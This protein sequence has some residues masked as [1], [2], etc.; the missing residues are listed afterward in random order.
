MDDEH[1][2]DDINDGIDELPLIQQLASIERE[3]QEDSLSTQHH[4]DWILKTVAVRIT[5]KYGLQ[6]WDNLG[7]KH[8]NYIVNDWKEADTGRRSIDEKLSALRWLT[9]KIGKANL[10]PRTNRELGVE[11]GARCTH[12]GNVISDERLA[13]IRGGIN[14]PRVQ[15]MIGLGREFGLRLKEASLFRPHQDATGN[16]AWVKRGTKGGRPRYVAVRTQGQRDALEAA[17]AVAEPGRGV[18]PSSV[19]TFEK[20][21]Q[22]VYRSLRAAG[23]SKARGATFH[24]LR[25]T[26]AVRRLADL[27]KRGVERRAASKLVSKE[28]GHSRLDI[29]D[30][31]IAAGDLGAAA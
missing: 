15:A 2:I 27:L 8:V 31:Y 25:R 22:H 21:R 7:Q 4:R 29:L 1:E 28:L 9:G 19:A 13:E 20:W 24:D 23:L 5:E 14:D 16:Y 18:I 17:R 26:Y 3:H 10:M 12:A 6:K 30:W 11:P